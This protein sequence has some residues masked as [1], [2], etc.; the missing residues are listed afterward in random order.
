[1]WEMPKWE[2]PVIE[3]PKVKPPVW[4]I[5]TSSENKEEDKIVSA[6]PLWE[7]IKPKL[8]DNTPNNLDTNIDIF[9]TPSNSTATANNNDV[10]NNINNNSFWIPVSDEKMETSSFP[11]INIPI[12][13]GLSSNDNFGF[14]ELN[15]N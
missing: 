4:N 14:P 7:N 6:V 11:N 1:M 9:N 12:N 2:E 5:P 8:G 13:D 10:N 3:E 15:N